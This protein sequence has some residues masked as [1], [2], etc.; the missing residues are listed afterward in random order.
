MN[1]ET[2]PHVLVVAKTKLVEGIAF[3][4]GDKGIGN[5]QGRLFVV[6][7]A[8]SVNMFELPDLA[9]GVLLLTE[10]VLHDVSEVGPVLPSIE[11][12]EDMNFIRH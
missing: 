11:L 8:G 4:D 6:V 10:V 7:F 3:E 2:F 12:G 5:G 9:N 1:F